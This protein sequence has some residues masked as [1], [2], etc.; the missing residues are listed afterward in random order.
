MNVIG[1]N[2]FMQ[3][4]ADSALARGTIRFASGDTCIKLM[5]GSEHFA[6]LLERA[7]G[8]LR[9][10]TW[11]WGEHGQL[12]SGSATDGGPCCVSEFAADQR[13]HVAAGAAFVVAVA[14]RVSK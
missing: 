14:T 5:A 9:I 3:H 12:G 11:G 8:V 13:V 1:P 4:G 6:A 10:V 2:D 7:D